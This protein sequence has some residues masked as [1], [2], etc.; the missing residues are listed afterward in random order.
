MKYKFCSICI[1]VTKYEVTFATNGELT[2]YTPWL[3][4]WW[5]L[6]HTVTRGFGTFVNNPVGKLYYKQWL[7]NIA[8]RYRHKILN[9]AN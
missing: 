7:Q 5:W 1:N 4:Y 9:L 3:C 8:C 6:Y 2:P